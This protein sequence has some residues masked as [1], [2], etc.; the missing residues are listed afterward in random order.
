MFENV[1]HTVL[2]AQGLR[3]VAFEDLM[4]SH[5]KCHF[6]ECLSGF[7]LGGCLPISPTNNRRSTSAGLMLGQR[8]RRWPSIEPALIQRLVFV[9]GSVCPYI[10]G[11]IVY[12]GCQTCI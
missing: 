3:Y 5:R 2:A 11:D 7:T 4:G 8:R 6:G 1:Y 9:E 10:S 12:L